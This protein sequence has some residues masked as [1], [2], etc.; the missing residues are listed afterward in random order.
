MSIAEQAP[1][2]AQATVRKPN[3][4]VANWGLLLAIAALVAV[5][6]LPTP[7]SLPVA[8]HRMLASG[9]A[10]HAVEQ[11]LTAVRVPDV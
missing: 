2:V 6:L 7:E 3:W 5:L 11:L 10:R 4:L 8:G 9:A 1:S